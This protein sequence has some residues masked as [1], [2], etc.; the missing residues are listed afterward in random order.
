MA[1]TGQ[2]APIPLGQD[3]MNG[4]DNLDLML[5]EQKEDLLNTSLAYGGVTKDGGSTKFNA[6]AL[7]APS[8]IIAGYDYWPDTGTQR[9]IALTSNGS[10]FKD[11]G[12]GTFGVTLASG[13]SWTTTTVPVFVESG[14]EAAA[15]NKKLFIF[16]GTDQV[17]VLSG[18]GA[19]TSNIGANRPADWATLFPICGANH[20]ARLWGAGNSSDPHRL[21]YSLATDH[22]DF[23]SAGAGT[24]AVF[25][26]EGQ[27]IVA[28]AS[29]YGIL[30]VW[31]FPRGLYLV[32]S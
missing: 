6:S 14:K 12:A 11:T 26:G 17:Q 28:I 3:G 2:I 4:T 1:Y 30:L 20:N 31:K 8:P 21:Y 22:E 13:K 7:G 23:T 29:F 18:D 19:T 9:T 16:T 15:N 5:P 24:V 27:K 25:P 10:A 32:D